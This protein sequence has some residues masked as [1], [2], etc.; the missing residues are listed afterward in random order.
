MSERLLTYASY[1]AR[2]VDAIINDV[3][4]GDERSLYN[5]SMHLIRAGGKRLRPLLVVLSA[6]IFGLREELALHPAA[7]VEILHNFTLI[8]DDIMDRD[9]FR[10][11]VP[12][13]H[14][15][16]GEAMAI[17]A[18]D[19]LFAKSYEAL[20]KLADYGIPL[21]RLM[22]AL[23]ELT[24]AAITVA[25][26]QALDMEFGRRTDVTIEEY[27][28]MVFK[29]TAALFKS[30]AYIGAVIAGAD[31][32]SLERISNFAKYIGI[33]FQIRDDELGLVGDEKVLGKP[34]YS[35]LREG[36]KTLPVIY[37]LSNV[38]EQSRKFLL[39]ILGNR[40]ACIDDLKRAAELIIESGALEYSNKMAEEFLSKGL[41]SI[42]GV[43]T[44][45]IEAKEMIKDFALFL[46]R[47][48]Y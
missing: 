30:S 23:K 21:D 36:K 11:G 9:E 29:K 34:V 43:R 38:S 20:L 44:N 4:R 39:N 32:E 14:K 31:E 13:V 24:W 12:T 15:V 45:D 41:A 5:A 6:R 47:R 22:M 10:R 40:S 17:L 19:L 35:D 42:E 27:L 3:V 2:K 25:E 28:K 8:H 48:Y 37:A 18:G 7:S 26:G 1:L 33:A 16:Y 46:T